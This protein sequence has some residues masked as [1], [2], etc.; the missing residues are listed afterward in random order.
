MTSWLHLQEYMLETL[1]PA[2]WRFC[3]LMRPKLSFLANRLN[4]MSGV[5]RASSEKHRSSCEAWWGQWHHAVRIM[6]LFS[7][8]Q[9]DWE[10]KINKEIMEENVMESAG[11]LWLGRSIMIVP[12]NIKP[13]L[14]EC[15]QNN[16]DVWSGQVHIQI[17]IQFKIYGGPLI[18]PMQP[19]WASCHM[20]KSD[21]NTSIQTLYR[22]IY[23]SVC[24]LFYLFVYLS[25]VLCIVLSIVLSV[26]SLYILFSH[27]VS[28]FV[29]SFYCSVILSLNR[30]CQAS[31]VIYY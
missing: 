9:I 4:G 15:L 1:K 30:L 24:L 28:T 31:V 29:L 26:L 17:S 7:R 16:V 6:L 18:I 2:G 19:D 25:V 22:S 3:G 21:R 5:S 12:A 14:E 11:Y 27:F 20:C 23:L 10:S 8:P 13:K